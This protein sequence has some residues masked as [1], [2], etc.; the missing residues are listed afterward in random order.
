[1]SWDAISATAEIIGAIAVVVSLVYVGRQFRYSSTFALENIYFQTVSN[2]SA[3]PDNARIVRLGNADFSSLTPD[4]QQHYTL[5]MH[6]LFSAID[7]IYI[8]RQNGLMTKESSDRGLKVAHFYYS[9]PGFREMWDRLLRDYFSPQLVSAVENGIIGSENQ[10]RTE[11]FP[12]END[13]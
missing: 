2:F 3:A 12:D 7:A 5:L 13:T 4:E 10:P 6:N 9:Q 11:L 8:Q 1:M